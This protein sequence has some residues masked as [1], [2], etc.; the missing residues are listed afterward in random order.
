VQSSKSCDNA[1]LSSVHTHSA[2]PLLSC[3]SSRVVPDASYPEVVRSALFVSSQSWVMQETRM[4]DPSVEFRKIAMTSL[5][6]LITVNIDRR[7]SSDGNDY[8]LA[9]ETIFRRRYHG[10]VVATMYSWDHTQT[11]ARPFRGR[12]TEVTWRE[13]ELEV[14]THEYVVM[15]LFHPPPR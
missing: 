10:A 1:R 5:D 2:V 15:G 6:L 11:A 8:F 12:R 4:K 7:C 13:A 3:D 9:A 14:T